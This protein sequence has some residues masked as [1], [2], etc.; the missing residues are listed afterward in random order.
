MAADPGNYERT[1]GAW[2]EGPT[3]ELLFSSDSHVMEPPDLLVSRVPQAFRDRAPR[4]PE[5]RVG[6][7]FQAHPG[8]SDPNERIKEM[9]VDGVS[10]E[11]LYPTPGLGLFALEDAAL[12]EACFRAYN[13]WLIEYCQVSLDRLIGIAMISTYNIDHAVQELERCAKA[14][15]RGAL[16]WQVP[17][18]ELSFTTDYY[19]RLWA[20]AQDLEMPVSLHILTGFGYARTLRDRKG[21]ER[22]RASVN[23]KL[24]EA[25]DALM[26][27][28]FSGVLERF[29][30]LKVVLVENEVGWIPYVLEQWDYYFNRHRS[31]APLTIDKRPSEYFD[32]QVYATFF[33]DA[34]GGHLFSWWGG[35][36]CMWS[37][38]FPHANSTWPR[39]REV[40]A[41]DLGHLPA[42]ARAKLVRENV[43]RLY[44]LSIPEPVA[45]PAS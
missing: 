11:V 16:V 9:A 32:R 29:P 15:L 24:G 39:S 19:D 42:T 37:N 14:G 26:D 30:R 8:G 35:E 2:T 36:N 41:R 7:G 33:N 44:N 22:Y 31:I 21:V 18:K 23:L 20:A 3:E 12:Q 5:Q 45:V 38:D 25:A 13:D 10:A 34:V 4:F 28:I 6:S 17:P 27:I 43:A 1:F 40:V